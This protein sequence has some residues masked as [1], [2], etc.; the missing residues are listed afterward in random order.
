MANINSMKMKREEPP[1][2]PKE[3]AKKMNRSGKPQPI[4]IHIQ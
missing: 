4:I 3:G 1:P 2:I